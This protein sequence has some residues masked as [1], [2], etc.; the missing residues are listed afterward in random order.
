MLTAVR[1][2]TYGNR[3]AS[4]S[5]QA[6]IVLGAAVQGDQPSPV[7]RERINHAVTL[8]RTGKVKTLLFT[9]G[10]GAGKRISEADAARNYAI[11]QGVP[12]SDTLIETESRTTFENLRNAKNLADRYH[13]QTFLIAS[14]PLHMRRSVV[15]A[16]DLGMTVKPSPTPTTRYRSVQSQWPFLLSETYQYLEYRLRP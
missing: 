12:A 3:T 8:Y 15:M 16:R 10:T 14:D 13:L 4:A 11:R 1:I 9:G 7:F 5:A 6:A 2:Y